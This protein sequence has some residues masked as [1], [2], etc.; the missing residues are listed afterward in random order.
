MKLIFADTFYWIALINPR[1]TWHF[2]ALDYAQKY[3]NDYLITTDGVI[4]ET[5]NNRQFKSEVHKL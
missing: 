3:A 2:I 5:L 4:D 1:D